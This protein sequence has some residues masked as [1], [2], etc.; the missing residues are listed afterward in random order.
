MVCNLELL[1]VVFG[2]PV[3]KLLQTSPSGFNATGDFDMRSFYDSVNTKQAVL[4]GE[5][6]DR[7]IDIICLTLGIERKGIKLNGLH[8]LNCPR[9]NRQ[10]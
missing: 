1:P 10:K 5:P 9:K 6:M 4:F 8:Y 2:L 3:N 7:L